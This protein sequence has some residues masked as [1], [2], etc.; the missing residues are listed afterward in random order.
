MPLCFPKLDNN[1]SYIISVAVSLQETAIP[2]AFV[3]LPV[4]ASHKTMSS[5]FTA[6]FQPFNTHQGQRDTATEMVLFRSVHYQ[7][8]RSWRMCV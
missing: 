8:C 1:H 7:L 2:A 5:P 6:T 4:S 3:E